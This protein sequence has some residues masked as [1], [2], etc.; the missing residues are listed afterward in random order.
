MST[1]TLQIEKKILLATPIA[2]LSLMGVW[3]IKR[4]AT[5]QI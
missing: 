4:L 3:E 1:T 5:Y 2:F